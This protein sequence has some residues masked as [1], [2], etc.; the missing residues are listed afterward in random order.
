M[1]GWLVVAASRDA[2]RARAA[3]QSHG[4]EHALAVYTSP[5][6]LADLVASGIAEGHSDFVAVGGDDTANLV[7]NALM[8]REW[9]S[10]PTLGML[11]TSSDFARTFALPRNFDD[12]A[13]TLT[14]GDRY[15]TDVGLVESGFGSRYFLNAVTAGLAPRS[16]HP[17]AALW[18]A[19]GSPR[20]AAVQVRSDG[21][22][23]EG[24][25]ISVVIANG[26]FTGGGLNVA[27]RTTVQDGVFDAQLISGRRRDLPQVWARMRRGTHLSLRSVRRTKGAE[28]AIDCPDSWPI[29]ADGESLGHGPVTV[30]VVPRAI[31][32]KL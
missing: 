9:E 24:E 14:G 18:I 19:L 6:E 1:K 11:S 26:Q 12:G 16:V 7:V 8:A 4:V 29:E 10:P 25:L 21:R 22:D 3:L 15:P 32:F 27:P 2:E 30:R 13:A 31:L 23:L 5:A 20:P 17:A 28:I